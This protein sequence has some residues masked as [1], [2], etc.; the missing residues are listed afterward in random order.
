MKMDWLLALEK[1]LLPRRLT[2]RIILSMVVIVVSAGLITAFAVN[3]MV[4]RHLRS[5]LIASGEALTLALGESIANALVE[6]DLA[7][8][9]EM[10]NAAVANNPD[11]L[12]AFAFGPTTP[13]VHTFRDG[14]PSD[15]LHVVSNVDE[16]PGAGVLLATELGAVRNFGY[17][18]LD[19]LPVEVHLGFS[20]ARIAAI[21]QQATAFVLMLTA[22]G[23]VVAVATTYTFSRLALRPLTELNQ[24]VQRLGEGHFDERATTVA[25][26]EVGDLA[27]AFNEMADQIQESI[28][29]IR[30]SEASYRDLLTAAAVVGEG[31]ALICDEGED[32]GNLLFVNEAFARMTGYATTEL[33]GS[34]AARVL[35]PDSVATARRAWRSVKSTQQPANPVELSLV[36][37]H[38]E[39]LILETTSTLTRYQ[40]RRALAWFMRDIT[41]RK[42]QEN[43]LRRRNRELS[44]LNAVA[45]AVSEMRSPPQMLE[46]ALEQVLQALDLTVGWVV[47]IEENGN[48]HVATW[49]GFDTP[50]ASGFPHCLCSAVASDHHPIIVTGDDT[51]CTARQALMHKGRPL[52]HATVA[53]QARSR[54]LGLLSVAAETP[55]V[56]TEPEIALLAAVGQQ[57]GVALENAH[58]WETLRQREQRRS[59]LLAQVI[60]AQEEERRRIARELHDG[61]GQ[62]I[63]ALVFGLNASAAVAHDPNQAAR[64]L[65]RLTMSASDIVKELQDVI[66]DLRPSLLDDLGLV[67]ALRWCAQERLSAQGVDVVL[68]TPEDAL[69]LPEEV[70]TALF[71]ISQESIANICRHAH[72]TQAWIGLKVGTDEVCMTIRDNGVGFDLDAF[73]TSEREQRPWGLLGMQERAALL[74]GRLYLDSEPG[75]GTT[76]RVCLPFGESEP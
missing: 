48:A 28:Q 57:I 43:E 50:P 26:D 25:D 51:R 12:Y 24:Q 14:F 40:G 72:A 67:M 8:M 36:N 53:I 41:Q 9:Q 56:F 37:R 30:F 3:Q 73:N 58:L 38:G 27:R 16:R 11:V 71:R 31:I 63:N 21:Q 68:D 49:R 17:R 70:E 15:L 35:H 61:I 66:Y 64:L 20:Q 76:V 23:S 4:S 29:Q 6:G 34:N 7:A 39:K 44:A 52:C 13:I 54:V 59:E 69:R 22:L 19:G 33:I 5:E 46:R 47:T 55:H 65:A 1:R 45:S 32:E 74:R 60:R 75:E 2:A 18:P 62:S 42:A 10:V